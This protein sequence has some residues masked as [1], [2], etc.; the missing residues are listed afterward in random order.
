MGGADAFAE[1]LPHR[2]PDQADATGRDDPLQLV[3]QLGFC[4]LTRGDRRGIFLDAAPTR[5][6]SGGRLRGKPQ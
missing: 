1:E 6:S 3:V 5:A 4:L 2:E